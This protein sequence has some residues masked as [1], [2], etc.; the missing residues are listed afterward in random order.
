MT[1]RDQKILVIVLAAAIGLFIL[2]VAV[3]TLWFSRVKA[4]D[5][6]AAGLDKEIRQVTAANKMAAE[7][8]RR[9]EGYSSRMIQANE[10][11]ASGMLA[12]T[13]S[14][15]LADS[16]MDGQLQAAQ[17]DSKSVGGNYKEI[18]QTIHIQGKLEHVIDFLYL[19]DAQPFLHRT[20]NLT[21]NRNLSSGSADVTFHYSVLIPDYKKKPI[22]GQPTTD[23]AAPENLNTP[24]RRQY[25]VIASRDLQ[26]PYVKRIV[27]AV[28][29]PPPTPFPT[30][31]PAPTPPPPRQ[32]EFNVCGLST[33]PGGE[34]DIVLRST[35][36]NEVRHFK[37]GDKL[38]NGA[39]AVMI[40]YRPMPAP[41]SRPDAP[42]PNSSSRLIMKIGQEFWSVEI[43]R[44]LSDK[45]PMNAEQLPPPLR[46]VPATSPV[47]VAGK[48]G[49][50]GK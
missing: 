44:N 29:T 16:H 5:D 20:D 35:R 10:S 49:P 26:R 43:E 14:R 4:L 45:R 50:A 18:G 48:A 47:E 2:Y 31:G 28:V 7:H 8:I 9:L 46:P 22:I 41:D 42:K 39:E 32:Q 13:V 11:Q 3:D 30:R 24:Q 12:S 34:Q 15:L 25:D 27:E 21:V 33:W 36:D 1:V 23:L 38:P 6:E 19:L 17:P 40:D 37:P